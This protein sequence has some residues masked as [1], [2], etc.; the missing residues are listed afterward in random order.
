MIL[1]KRH[2][3]PA[4]ISLNI[5]SLMDMFT[6]LLVFLLLNFS[7]TSFDLKMSGRVVFPESVSEKEL[8]DVVMMSVDKYSINVEGRFVANH[9][10]GVIQET[11][12]DETG[13]KII[14]LYNELIRQAQR[15]KNV[16]VSE[17]KENGPT[18]KIILQMDKSLPFFLLRQVMYT[19]GQAEYN[20]FKFIAVKK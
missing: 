11:Y 8:I 9:E 5:T 10:N 12:L 2:R 18:G 19:A 16:T 4:S 3:R 20:D 7:A 1:F 6:I 13:Y 15:T 17:N 14:P